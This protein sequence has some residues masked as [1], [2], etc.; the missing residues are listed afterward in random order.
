VKSGTLI[1]YDC[2]SIYYIIDENDNGINEIGDTTVVVD[3]VCPDLQPGDTLTFDVTPAIEYFLFGT[4][5][6]ALSGF[7]LKNVWPCGGSTVEFFDHTDYVLGPTLYVMNTDTD[8]DDILDDGDNSGTPGDN[9]CTGGEIEDCDD[10]CP[11]YYNTDQ[12]DSD[13]DGTGDVCDNCPVASN[14]DQEDT[15]PP[16]GNGIGDACECE[17]DF[18]C[19]G[20]VDGSDASTFKSDF[21]RSVIV[22][23]CIDRDTCNGDF[24]C[25]GDVDGTDASLFKSDFGRSS[26]QN[27]CPGCVQ[28]EWCGYGGALCQRL[29]GQRLSGCLYGSCGGHLR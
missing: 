25:D 4:D 6:T 26:I 14:H 16:G 21:G 9:H 29:L 20:D 1:G 19:D 23:P 3:G 11:V 28:G 27:P 8:E 17:G 24:S 12:M 18:A 7:L 22:H 13:S 5:Q 2:L 15:C 10:N